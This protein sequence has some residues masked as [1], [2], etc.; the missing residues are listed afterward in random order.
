MKMLRGLLGSLKAF[1]NIW[2]SVCHLRGCQ[3][4]GEGD[5]SMKHAC[6]DQSEQDEG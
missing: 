5:P 2:K 3:L 6:L 1:Q 4:E